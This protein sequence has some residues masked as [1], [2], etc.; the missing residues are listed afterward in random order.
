MKFHTTN[1]CASKYSIFALP[2]LILFS[3]FF[4]FS[5]SVNAQYLVKNRE[6]LHPPIK[7][8]ETS[9][10]ERSGKV[11]SIRD[12]ESLEVQSA[13]E[14]D[15]SSLVYKPDEAPFGISYGNWGAY[16]WQWA[17][18][19]PASIHPGSLDRK[20][21][22]ANAQLGQAGPVY[23]FS[24]NYQGTT[25][26]S[27]FLVPADR[28]IFFPV[29]TVGFFFAPSDTIEG[30]LRRA[31]EDANFIVN[32]VNKI[33]VEIDHQPV[34]ETSIVRARSRLFSTNLPK[35]NV[36]EPFGLHQGVYPSSAEGYY[37]MIKPLSPGTHV[38][39]TAASHNFGFSTHS[40]F[41][42]CVTDYAERN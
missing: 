8:D 15:V 11:E 7:V 36:F 4:A 27:E 33:W 18:S 30:F 16:W 10:V 41:Y 37:I 35:G 3:L 6:A 40:E 13:T 29:Y 14:A 9:K 32:N 21:S 31:D 22:G 19:I 20:I 28:A 25:S 23:F 26:E 12:S 34:P 24:P 2:C 5:L 17:M 38:I 42:I 1:R 39:K